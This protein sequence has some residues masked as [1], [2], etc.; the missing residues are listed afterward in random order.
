MMP[1]RLPQARTLPARVILAGEG[2]EGS[3]GRCL[4]LWLGSQSRN[5]MVHKAGQVSWGA[6]FQVI[7]STRLSPRSPQEVGIF[8][9]LL[10]PEAAV[11]GLGWVGEI[12]VAFNASSMPPSLPLAQGL[13]CQATLVPLT[14]RAPLL[15]RAL[16][17]PPLLSHP[18]PPHKK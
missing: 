1:K 17:D 3:A 4:S 14:P 12:W 9:D 18:P 7:F 15:L 5:Y 16:T 13:L 6:P 11:R 8:Q 2:E 10:P